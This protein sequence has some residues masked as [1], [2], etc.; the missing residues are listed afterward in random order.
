MPLPALQRFH[1]L[2]MHPW[3]P[4]DFGI[5]GDTSRRL[6]LLVFISLTCLSL[7]K[8]ERALRHWVIARRISQGTRTEQ[9]SR[10]VAL[11][12]SVIDTCRKRDVLP[13]PYLARV[14]AERRKGH[15]A[16]PLPAGR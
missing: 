1:F 12:A 13:W 10:V 11:L 9:G 7:P 2:G 3:A 4:Q 6:I 14:V 5:F 8:A 15:S 16:P